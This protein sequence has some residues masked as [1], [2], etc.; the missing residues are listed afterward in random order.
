MFQARS[1]KV[2][3]FASSLVRY[4]LNFR[5][6]VILSAHPQQRSSSGDIAPGQGPLLC[7]KVIRCVLCVFL[8]TAGAMA[9]TDSSTS[10]GGAK[11]SKL[12]T[13]KVSKDLET[14]A[15]S[16]TPA[17]LDVSC[18]GSSSEF[19]ADT[20]LHGNKWQAAHHSRFA[21]V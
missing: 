10:S 8:P 12:S 13:C 9:S 21:I 4:W 3:G 6:V 7:M 2:F 18:R 11:R 5:H 14:T 17:H 15:E 19:V 1:S 20:A 16:V